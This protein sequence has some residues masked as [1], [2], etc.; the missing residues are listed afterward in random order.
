MRKDALQ[1]ELYL[2]TNGN[3][4]VLGLARMGARQF[5][6]METFP[7]NGKD[8]PVTMIKRTARADSRGQTVLCREEILLQNRNRSTKR[9]CLGI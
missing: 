3:E 1:I 2:A 5:Q 8:L 4:E 6:L 7:V 9:Q